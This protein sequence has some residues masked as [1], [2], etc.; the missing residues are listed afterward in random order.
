MGGETL[1]DQRLIARGQAGVIQFQRLAH[2]QLALRQRERRQLPE[3]FGETH[4]ARAGQCAPARKCGFEI[5]SARP[6]LELADG[7]KAWLK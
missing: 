2:E 4:G 6:R 3:D 1:L 5:G 7:A